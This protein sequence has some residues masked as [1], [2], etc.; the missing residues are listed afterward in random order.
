MSVNKFMQMYGDVSPSASWAVSNE[1]IVI[2]M[3]LVTF[4][5]LMLHNGELAQWR[6]GG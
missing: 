3:A 4:V 5:V 1:I 2:F 6:V